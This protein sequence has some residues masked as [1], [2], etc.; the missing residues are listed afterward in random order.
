MKKLILIISVFCSFLSVAQYPVNTGA[1]SPSTL[2]YQFGSYGGMIGFVFKGTYSDTT[3]ANVGFI[4]NV[5]GQVIRIG[6]S[7]WIRNNTVTRWMNLMREGTST[8]IYNS[9]GILSS[10]REVDMST[11]SLSF[12]SGDIIKNSVVL[13]NTTGAKSVEIK[14]GDGDYVGVG[15]A[16]S[17]YQDSTGIY[18]V[19][20]GTTSQQNMQISDTKFFTQVASLLT[21]KVTEITAD[22][23]KITFRAANGVRFQ[24]YGSGTY[25][26]TPSFAL[27]VDASGNIIEGSVSGAETDPLSWHLAGT[28]SL[29]S[30][31]TINL[32]NNQLNFQNGGGG[33]WL[34]S[35]LWAGVNRYIVWGDAVNTWNSTRLRVDDVNQYIEVHSN[36]FNITDASLATASNTYVWTLIDQTTG[37]GGWAPVT[38]GSGEVNTGSNLGGGLA[39]Y[40]T[41]VGVD[42][43]FNSFDAADFDLASNLI[44]I[45]A[46]KWLTQSSAASA[47][48]PLDGD[49]T[50]LAGFT[51]SANVKTI[52]NAADYAAIKTALSLTIGTDVQAFDADLTTYAG[53][54]PSANVQTL[55]GSADY[56]A[57]RTSLGLVIGTNVQAFD[58]DL[59]TWAGLTPTTVGQNL[60]TLTNPSAITFL[61]VNADNTVTAR[62]AANFRTD[63]SLVPGTDVQAFDADLT[64]YAGITPSANV[65]TLLGAA[66]FSAFRTSLGLVI[67]TNVQ[68]FDADLT[69]WA[70]LTPTTVGQN[71]VTL[72]N[73]S[74]ITFLRINADNTVTARSAANFKTDLSLTI[75]T[76]VQAFDADL[77]IWAGITPATGVGTFLATPSSANLASAVTDETGTGSLMFGTSPRITT[78][79]NDAN[80]NELFL[81]TAT[82]SAVNEITIAN[83]ATTANA[84]IT[85][86][87]EANTGITITGKGTK[88]VSIGNAF[89]EKVVTVSDGAG[90]VIDASLGNYFS[91]TAA[92]D[93][94]AGTT[95]NPTTGQK[96]IIAFTASGGARTLTLPTATTGDFL[97]G[98]DITAL[99]QTVS[100]K[101][102]LIGCIY[103][104][105]R[106]MVV[107]YTKGF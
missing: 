103:N 106:F 7:L 19:I 13:T 49:L 4:K 57:F 27:Q 102:D 52:L 6:D 67:G 55:L 88:G 30:T 17:Y 105:T 31:A 46:T 51:P 71:I 60:V 15:H 38:G 104:G 70:G 35:I 1:G 62:S 82:A 50:Y 79:I 12:Y 69:T 39:N 16:S 26:G 43:Q 80:G 63:L 32:N 74:A 14:Y 20:H 101:T 11:K 34:G 5:P 89:L 29:T 18:P 59:S 45:D 91:W 107:A 36:K 8:N 22:T 83:G 85:A 81:F 56:S 64:T 98:T 37:E 96:L 76:D 2:Q 99:T 84:T 66:D 90:A 78:G 9:N 48:Q 40:S 87:G 28:S 100:G 97:F 92:A 24:D 53:I 68:A 58:A 10:D 94:T 47:Y 65:Q 42:L 23:S 21:S 86:S 93:R 3:A 61:R 41:K 95:T 72:A 75:G 33:S 77:T 44:S 73:P 54:T 25:T